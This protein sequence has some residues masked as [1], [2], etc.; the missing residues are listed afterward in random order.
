MAKKSVDQR[1]TAAA[2]ASPQQPCGS[3][4]TWGVSVQDGSNRAWGVSAQ[5]DSNRAL[6]VS[7][8]DDSNRALGV[9]AQDDSNGTLGVS[10]QDGSNRAWGVSAQDDSN[11]T[12]GAS[13]KDDSNGTWAVTV[14]DD[15]NRTLGVSAQDSHSRP[16]CHIGWVQREPLWLQAYVSLSA[17]SQGSTCSWQYIPSSVLH[18]QY[19]SYLLDMVCASRTGSASQA[20]HVLTLK[21][22]QGVAKW[23][24]ASSGSWV[25][26]ALSQV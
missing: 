18:K 14:Q 6:G 16:R 3:N 12:W 13:V 7:A 10:A 21:V 5:D 23:S 19:R 26:W 4:E 2:V 17:A 9:S 25:I 1:N 11:G 15:S 20:C 8:Q 24:A 22:Q